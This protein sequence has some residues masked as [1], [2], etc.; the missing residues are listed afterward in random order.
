VVY[1]DEQRRRVQQ[2]VLVSVLTS[3]CPRDPLQN[4]REL[5]CTGALG[6]LLRERLDTTVHVW[7]PFCS[8]G[9]ALP[10][11]QEKNIVRMV[12]DSLIAWPGSYHASPNG[13]MLSSARRTARHQ[14]QW[15]RVVHDSF[16]F[17]QRD[18]VPHRPQPTS[19]GFGRQPAR[20]RARRRAA[21]G[22]QSRAPC[23]GSVFYVDC[24]AACLYEQ[25]VSTR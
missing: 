16:P 3:S 11:I 9:D 14:G 2:C 6:A 5:V 18:S 10:H 4:G 15:V 12:F 25:A 21:G 13:R 7:S 22:A 19:R 23:S 8:S 20:L 24:M 1:P 17:T